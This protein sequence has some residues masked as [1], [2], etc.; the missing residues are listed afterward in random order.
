MKVELNEKELI[1]IK[2]HL[3][4][5]RMYKGMKLPHN[6]VHW[7]EEWMQPFIDKIYDAINHSKL[8]TPLEK[9]TKEDTQ[10]SIIKNV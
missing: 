6:V 7:E 9:A 5:N 1:Y 3:L 2:W 8:A 4:S 10:T